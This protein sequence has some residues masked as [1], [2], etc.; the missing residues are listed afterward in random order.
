MQKGP[1][2]LQSTPVWAHAFHIMDLNGIAWAH[3]GV[4]GLRLPFNGF[5]WV[6]VADFGGFLNKEGTPQTGS[7]SGV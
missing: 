7:I 5:Y 1:A 4:N 3:M 2:P 6:N